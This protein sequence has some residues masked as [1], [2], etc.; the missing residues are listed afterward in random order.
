M[1]LLGHPKYHAVNV[2]RDK[3][4]E[5]FTVKDFFRNYI[6]VEA[7]FKHPKEVKYP[8]IPQNVDDTTTIFPK[9][10]KSFMT[11]FEYLLAKNLGCK[12]E[13]VT[14]TAVP[15]LTL[16]LN[17]LSGGL[18]NDEKFERKLAYAAKFERDLMEENVGCLLDYSKDAPFIEIVKRI[19]AKRRQYD[20]KTFENLFYKL[21]GNTGYGLISQGLGGKRKFDIKTN[22]M[23]VMT[24]GIFSNPVLAASITGFIR[25]VI[26]ETLNNIKDLGGRVISVT[27][28]G[29]ITDIQDL[30][31]KLLKL[32]FQKT[33]MFRCYRVIRK[34]LSNN[35]EAY[36]L[37]HVEREGII[38]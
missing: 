11:G 9:S 38:S 33:M 2:H 34:E 17:E 23:A 16:E 18:A 19:Q 13:K 10:G 20:K 25:S 6:S 30:E 37:K 31:E 21:L 3:A 24:A 8:G 26:A 1:S 32:D 27:T 14:L 15:F 12:F 7:R 5:K 4:V 36:E 28:D 22:D 35:P 29:F